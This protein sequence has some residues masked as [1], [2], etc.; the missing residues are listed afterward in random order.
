M[1]ILIICYKSNDSIF[2]LLSVL[3]VYYRNFFETG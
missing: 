1:L 2:L 3:L